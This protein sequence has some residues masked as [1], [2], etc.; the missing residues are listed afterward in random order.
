MRLLV[1]EM[2]GASKRYATV[3]VDDAVDDAARRN[4]SSVRRCAMI[5]LVMVLLVVDV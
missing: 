5:S 4:V 1:V 3:D 2:A